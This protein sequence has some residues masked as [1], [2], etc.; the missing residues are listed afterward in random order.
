[1]KTK[2][3][4]QVIS[5]KMLQ[6]F[7]SIEDNTVKNIAKAN[8]IVSGGCIT[9]MLLKEKV[10]DYDVYFRTREAALAVAEYYLDQFTKNYTVRHGSGKIVKTELRVDEDTGRIKFHIQSAG[11][12]SES[13]T[14]KYEYFETRPEDE[15]AAYAEE[16][17]KA[18]EG[19]PVEVKEELKNKKYRPVFFTD[20]SITLTDDIQ[21]VIRFFGEPEQILENYDYQHCKNYW[22]SWGSKKDTRLILNQHSLECI[23][24]KELVYTGSLYPVCSLFRMRKFINRGWT[25]TAGQILKMVVQTNALD[26][27]QIPVLREQLIGVDVA[28]FNQMID[29][30]S[31]TNKDTID[32]GYLTTLID[33]LF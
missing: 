9:S 28:Y 24:A 31:K 11:V 32:S 5:K 19:V 27:N 20:N 12:L 23:L 15:T 1:M 30:L 33:R 21:I 7:D 22:C 4:D 6:W 29:L 14:D 17:F 8:T 18:I 25:I 3:I 10:N 26:L 13:K 16:V 2:T